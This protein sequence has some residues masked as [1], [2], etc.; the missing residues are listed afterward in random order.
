MNLDER[1]AFQFAEAWSMLRDVI[2]SCDDE[3]WRAPTDGFRNIARLAY[4][5]VETV[6]DYVHED[7]DAFPWA[8]RFGVDWETDN[9]AAL[10]TPEEI[11]TY[12]AEVEAKAAAWI[13]DLGQDGLLE[14]DAVFHKEGMSHLDRALYVLRHTQHHI[15][16]IASVFR[17][18]AIPRPAWR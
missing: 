9:L 5:V 8:E 16:E 10:P 2:A 4:H 11:D 13:A 7:L 3:G 17:L 1:I 15:G 6:D 12:I 18:R 14:P